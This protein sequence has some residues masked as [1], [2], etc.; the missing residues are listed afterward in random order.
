MDASETVKYFA[1]SLRANLRAKLASSVVGVAA[2]T[3]AIWEQIEE[4]CFYAASLPIANEAKKLFV[5]DVATQSFEILL[6]AA[7]LPIWA[8]AIRWKLV[9]KRITWAASRV[10][11]VISEKIYQRAVKPK[12]PK[13]I[14]D[15]TQLPYS[16]QK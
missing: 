10:L 16:G 11:P 8:K 9:A 6:A 14:H 4:A 5:S 7:P 12:L 3:D 1:A 2:F 13:V 15:D